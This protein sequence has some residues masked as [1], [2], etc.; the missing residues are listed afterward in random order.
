MA[1]IQTNVKESVFSVKRWRGVNEA[2]EGEAALKN[3]E[4]A[5]CK[6]FRV[7]SGGAL[8]K[9]NGSKNVAGLMSAYNASVDRTNPVIANTSFGINSFTMYPR[10]SV[11]SVGNIAG[12]GTAVEV[13]ADDAED[14]TGY[15]FRIG[16]D[17]YELIEAT[18][19]ETA[20]GENV[21]GGGVELGAL[22]AFATGSDTTMESRI[23]I[24]ALHCRER[25][26]A[27]TSHT[28]TING[29]SR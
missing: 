3:G 11:D 18:V 9:R 1:K 27:E 2:E 15:V 20:S 5:V 23:A 7:T 22:T 10:F 21:R 26:F 29:A 17:A 25:M 4:G 19:E 8:K 14:Y 6:N 28:S 16:V 24:E 12:E 13:F